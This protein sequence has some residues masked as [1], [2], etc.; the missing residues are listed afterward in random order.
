MKVF[1]IG[2]RA[3]IT[4]WLEHAAAGFA[5]AGHQ[6]RT[7]AVRNPILHRSI[8]AALADR[9]LGAPMARAIAGAV[10][11]FAPDL[12]I[13]VGVYKAPLVVLERLAAMPGRPPLIAWIGD[14]FGPEEAVAAA[15]FDLVAYTDSGLLARHRELGF[16]S[17]AMWLPHAVDPSRMATAGDRDGPRGAMAFVAI[18]T[19]HR[20][21]VV[22]GLARPIGLWGPGWTATGGAAHQVHARRI[23]PAAVRQVYAG[24]LAVLNIRHEANVLDGLNQRSFEP[25]LAG[26]PVVSDNQP[27]LE[28]CFDLATEVLVWRDVGELNAVHERLIAEPGLAAKVAAAGR[29]RVLAEH[30]YGA[31]LEALME[32][33]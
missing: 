19:P 25:Y 2:K 29:R 10:R 7:A 3:S 14:A 13:V 12:V 4:H 28:R 11:R 24:A 9:R 5:S 15:H 20:R 16:A 1:L 32:A 30:T 23:A 6:V 21:Q 17:R 18:P 33:V 31:R 26:A 27:D 8:D 22:A